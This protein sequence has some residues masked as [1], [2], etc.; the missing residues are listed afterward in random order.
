MQ[1]VA[2]SWLIYRMTGSALLLGKTAFASQIPVFLL[3]PLGGIVA[4]RFNRHRIILTTQTCA[5]VLAGAYAF[6]TLTNRIN[7][8]EIIIIAA[9][10]GTVN[11]FDL[12][13]RQAFIVEMVGREDLVNAIALNSSMFNGARIIGPAVAGLLVAAIGERWCFAANAVSYI[14]VIA[15]L[16]MMKLVPRTRTV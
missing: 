9:C 16:M 13:A 4:D 10:L 6:L 1:T 2:E 14:A 11:A 15:G 8:K 5:M 12:P 3:S 7:V